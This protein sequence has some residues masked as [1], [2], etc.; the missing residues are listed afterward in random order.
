MFFSLLD[1][2]SFRQDL[3]IS[4]SFHTMLC[5][6]FTVHSLF[7]SVVYLP[8]VKAIQANLTQDI[9]KPGMAANVLGGFFFG[10][11]S[12]LFFFIYLF[13]FLFLFFCS[14]TFDATSFISFFPFFLFYC[15]FMTLSIVYSFFIHKS[16]S[17]S[18]RNGLQ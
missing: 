4:H 9:Y 5:W 12:F 18:R 13:C 14:F 2:V 3:E 16:L 15:L 8:S 7:C 10:L 6:M 17:F 11:V 1:S